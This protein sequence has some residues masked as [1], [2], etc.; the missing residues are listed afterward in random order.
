VTTSVAVA[1]QRDKIEAPQ[2]E[3]S[4]TGKYVSVNHAIAITHGEGQLA[5]FDKCTVVVDKTKSFRPS[6]NIK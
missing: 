3:S 1:F 2:G 4:K 5:G 6:F